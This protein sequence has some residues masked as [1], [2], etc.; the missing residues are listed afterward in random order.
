[1]KHRKIS[2]V[3]LSGALLIWSF[4][5]CSTWNKLDEREK[6]AVIGG[7]SGAVVGNAVSPGAGGTVV[8]GALGAVA[9]GVIG[10]EVRKDE[11]RER[12]ARYREYR[13]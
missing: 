6:G 11:E 12:R 1:M 2:V 10:N 3:V 4:G 9:G 7:G 5:G 13:D 8:G